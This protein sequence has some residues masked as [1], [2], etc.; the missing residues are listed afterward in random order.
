[1]RSVYCKVLLLMCNGI[2]K[3]ASKSTWGASLSLSTRGKNVT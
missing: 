2:P 1:M 3:D